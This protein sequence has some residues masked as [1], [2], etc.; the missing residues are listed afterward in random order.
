MKKCPRCGLTFA[1]DERY[2]T[3]CGT[4]LEEVIP[5]SSETAEN[6]EPAEPSENAESSERAENAESSEKSERSE[7]TGN[8]ES[9]ESSEGAEASGISGSSGTSETSE[10]S[11]SS[12]SSKD[13]LSEALGEFGAAAK[14][15]AE[16][17]GDKAKEGYEKM[18]DDET[19]AKYSGKAKEGFGKV[20]D[21]PDST[22]EYEADDVENYKIISIFA[23]CGILFIVPL[24]AGKDSKY[25]RF[26]TNQGIILFIFYIILIFLSTLPTIG[27]VFK[28]GHL[29]VAILAILG[30]FHAITGKARELPLIGKFRILK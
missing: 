25:A 19:F 16:K 2:C 23:Y 26:H 17:I 5:E 11:D 28:L 13:E 3:S 1:D 27:W 21:T 22:S 29:L 10:S 20:M 8:P 9:S 18:K 7:N 30:I 12:Q 24:L 14:K 15:L 4:P 6:A